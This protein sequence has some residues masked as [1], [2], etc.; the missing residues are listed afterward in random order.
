MWTP[1]QSARLRVARAIVARFVRDL[2][3]AGMEHP[4]DGEKIERLSAGL[5]KAEE[6]ARR[7]ADGRFDSR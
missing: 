7:A 3:D 5:L 1:K 6:R 4:C 2:E